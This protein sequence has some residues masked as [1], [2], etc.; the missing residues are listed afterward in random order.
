MEHEFPVLL[1][2]MMGLSISMCGSVMQSTVK[3]IPSQEPYVLRAL[4]IA[5][6]GAA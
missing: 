2:L 5:T 6:L 1:G 3:T 4:R